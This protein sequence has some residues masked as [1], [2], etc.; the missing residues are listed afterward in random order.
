LLLFF[1]AMLMNADTLDDAV[2][3]LARSIAS[4]LSAGEVA[5]LSERSLAP[6]FAAETSR[7]KNLLDRAL[8]PPTNS[9]ATPVDVVVTATENA[10]GPLLVVQIQK[11]QETLVQTASYTAAPAA[12]TS[13]PVLASRVLWEQDE[14]ILDLVTIDEE[15]LVLSASDVTRY[16][17]TPAGWERAE[18]RPVP[19]A[20]RDPRG[21]MMISGESITIFLPGGTCQGQRKSSLQ[22]NCEETQTEFLL[23]GENVRFTP[24]GNTLE[25]S[26]DKFYSVTHAGNVRLI[27]ELNGRIHASQGQQTFAWDGWGSDVV[28]INGGCATG[29]LVI[30][31]SANGRGS[32]DSL[33]PLEVTGQSPR[34]AGDPLTMPGPVTALWPVSGGA[35]AVVRQLATGKYGAYNITLDCSR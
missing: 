2:R 22:W 10:R 7:A 16:R 12:R 23:D 25:N 15:M 5:R 27:T 20:G 35:L 17:R 1:G 30:V 28:A 13:R 24:G 26:T 8:R 14:P 34:T 3:A 33:T 11:G 21:R 32:T 29:P 18:S 19:P 31:G 4:Q 9:S 6:A